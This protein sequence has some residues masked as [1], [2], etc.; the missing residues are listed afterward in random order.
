MKIGKKFGNWK[1]FESVGAS[2]A[3]GLEMK[4]RGCETKGRKRWNCE[5]KIS[6]EIKCKLATANEVVTQQA[7]E[8]RNEKEMQRRVE[9]NEK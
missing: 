2:H 4:G 1:K 7:V 9:E 5:A 6:C 3:E 8:G